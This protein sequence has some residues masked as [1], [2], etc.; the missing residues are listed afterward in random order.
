MIKVNYGCGSIQ[1]EG[2]INVDSDNDFNVLTNL[3]SVNNDSVDIMVAH[4]IIQ[5]IEWHDL[6]KQLS[7]L[8]DK[9]KEGGVLR[10][11]LPDIQRGFKALEE[12]DHE[13]FP[14]G[15]DDIHERFCAW[16]TWYST[17]ITL[18]TPEALIDKLKAAGFE[19][20]QRVQFKETVFSDSSITELDTRKNEFY[21]M[22]ARK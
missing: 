16:I 15:E 1:P 14:N 7:D 11:S 2:W 12:Y 9:L 6:V 21:F 4:A 13:W 20:V 10:I 3:D 5:Q 17:S 18:L 19:F 8:R 22:E